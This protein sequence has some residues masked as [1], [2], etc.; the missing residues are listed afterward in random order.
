EFRRP[1]QSRMTDAEWMA[2]I[3]RGE[4]PDAPDWTH[5]LRAPPR[6]RGRGLPSYQPAMEPPNWDRL[7]PPPAPPPAVPLP[8]GEMGKA[9]SPSLEGWA[10]LGLLGPNPTLTLVGNSRPPS[11]R[12]SLGR[13]GHPAKEKTV[14]PEDRAEFATSRLC[15]LCDTR[16]D[17]NGVGSG[18]LG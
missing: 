15:R 1:V 9:P 12:R 17:E 7:V 8:L 16:Y 13:M 11:I 10:N 2:M 6:E 18:R 3:H 14:G 4:L 5:S